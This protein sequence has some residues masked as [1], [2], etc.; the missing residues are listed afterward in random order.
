MLVT[1]GIYSYIRH[2][3]YAGLWLWAIAQPL[4]LQNWLAGF[5]LLVLFTPLYFT[6][7]PR[8]EGLMLDY[9]GEEYRAYMGRTGRILPRLR[10]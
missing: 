1:D 5:A 2:P 4:L 10:R 8:E 6:R 3:I 9:F 7:R